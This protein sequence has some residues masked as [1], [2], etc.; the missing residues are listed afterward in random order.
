MHISLLIF[1]FPRHV[2][3]IYEIYNDKKVLDKL[4]QAKQQKVF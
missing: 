1:I 4:Q 3:I 2:P